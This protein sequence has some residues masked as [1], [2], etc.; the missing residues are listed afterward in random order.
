MFYAKDHK[1]GYLCS[2]GPFNWLGPKRTKLF[3]QS[4]A[5][6]FRDRILP[7]LPVDRLRKYYHSSRGAPTKELAA[8]L[9]VMILQQMQDLTDEETVYQ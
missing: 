1:T 6:I 8:M 7:N 5:L 3:E 4:W 2:H 9:G